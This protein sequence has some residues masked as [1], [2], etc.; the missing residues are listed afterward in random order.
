MFKKSIR[1]PLIYFIVSIIYQLVIHQE[2]RWIENLFICSAMFM[3]YMLYYWAKI[4]YEWKKRSD[5]S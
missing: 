4:P 2:V 1:Y 5:E 3:I